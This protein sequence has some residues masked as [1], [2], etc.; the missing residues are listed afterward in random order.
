[1][2]RFHFRL[3]NVL[4]WRVVQ[5]ETEEAKL[6]QLFAERNRIDAA[7]E[8]LAA[9]LAASEQSVQQARVI[10]A[11]ELMALEAHREYAARMREQLLAARRDCE[12]RIAKQRERVTNAER[13]VRLLEKLKER[14]LAEWHTAADKEM[15]ALASEV[16]LA[17]W[18]RA[19]GRR[20]S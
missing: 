3:Q 1:M 13:D 18:H 7:R 10:E 4:E 17:Q 6:E 14:R 15:E 2:R 12:E 20:T 16:Y 11:H 9:A 19:G 5:L 8:N